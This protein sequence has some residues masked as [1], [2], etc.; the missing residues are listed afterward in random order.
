MSNSRTYH[1][2]RNISASIG[3]QVLNVLLSFF[4]RTVFLYA[5]NV[6]YLGISGLFGDIF[7]MLCLAD[8]GI[9]TAMT[10]NMYKPLAEG[11]YDRVAGLV[12][13][14]RRIY[15]TIAMVVTGI[16]LSL[17]PFLKYLVNLESDMPHLEL[18][19]VLGL[20]NTVAS[21]LVV[22]KTAVVNADQKS[23]LITKYSMVFIVLRSIFTAVFLVLTH[24]YIIYLILQVVFTYLPNFFSSYIAEKNYPFIKKKVQLPKGEAKQIFGNVWSVFLYKISGVLINATDNTLISVLVNTAAV[25]YYSNYSMIVTRLSGIINTIF[26]SLTSSLGNL[27]VKENEHRRYEIFKIMQSVSQILSAFCVVCVFAL[28]EDFIRLWLGPDYVLDRLVLWAM[29]L[30][31]CFSIILLP[32]WVFREA[33]GLYNKTKY[34]MLVTAAVNIVVSV[35]L[36]RMLGLAGIIFATSIARLLTYFWYEPILLFR[37]YFGQSSLVYFWGVLKSLAVTAVIML[38]ISWIGSM[39]RVDSLMEL[40]MKGILLAALTLGFVVLAYFRTEGFKL[41]LGRA[42]AM[43]PGKK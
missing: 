19:Y 10:Y 37:N 6:E 39:I 13:L 11:D 28:E 31:F 29:V 21:Y 40:L 2:I 30:N 33:A 18:Y 17:I 15:H 3:F 16:G 43:L 34:V 36:G 24:N 41:I 23:Y 35:I 20:A 1:A 7:S 9:G 32:I 27:I 22:Y 38:V 26:Y 5:L 14:Y 4:N 42:R 25:G 12:G 8:L